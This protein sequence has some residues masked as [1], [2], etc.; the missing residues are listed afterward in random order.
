VTS[1]SIQGLSREVRAWDLMAD[2]SEKPK[3]GRTSFYVSIVSAFP[4]F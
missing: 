1:G 4:A 2:K 3:S